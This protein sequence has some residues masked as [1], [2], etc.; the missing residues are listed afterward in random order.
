MTARVP[1]QQSNFFDKYF[2]PQSSLLNIQNSRIKTEM[3]CIKPLSS[4]YPR[5]PII[6]KGNSSNPKSGWDR[7]FPVPGAF[8]RDHLHPLTP[9]KIWNSP[10]IR[11]RL[12][13]FHFSSV[14]VSLRRGSKGLV[15]KQVDKRPIKITCIK[16][17]FIQ[18]NRDRLLSDVWCFGLTWT[19]LS[20]IGRP[21]TWA[22][23]TPETR[24][25]GCKE[26]VQ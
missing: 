6:R 13:I 9:L 25:R 14:L 20:K 5:G 2:L 10:V 24:L 11:V 22:R 3:F 21:W 8:K 16:L 23:K 12:I 4:Y 17:H 18:G 1:L 7:G 26:Y 15:R 19:N